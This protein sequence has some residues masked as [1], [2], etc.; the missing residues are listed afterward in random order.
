MLHLDLDGAYAD[1]MERALYNG[2][3]TG[4]S[5]EGEHYFYANP[6]ES[7]GQ[8]RRWAWHLCPCCTMNVSRLVASVGGYFL[9]ASENGVAFHLYGGVSAAIDIGGV[10]VRVS[11]TSDYPWSGDVRIAID[12]ATAADFE[13]KLRIPEWARSPSASINGESVTLEI[14]EGYTTLPRKWR[15]GDVVALTPADAAG[16]ALR[17]PKSPHGRRARRP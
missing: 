16:A 7:R 1:M 8:H 14:V 4:L 10:S 15:S 13:L 12:P 17:S 9:S 5:R 6:L 11:E 3:L 2:A